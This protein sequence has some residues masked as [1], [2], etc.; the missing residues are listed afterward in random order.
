MIGRRLLLR[1]Q[2]EHPEV[3]FIPEE[4]IDGL[5]VQ[6]NIGSHV[7]HNYRPNE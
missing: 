1:Y 7:I 2:P 3:R 6:Q 4:F 5:Q